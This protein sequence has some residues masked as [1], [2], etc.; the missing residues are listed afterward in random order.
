MML[1]YPRWL[2]R[3]EAFDA[4]LL[5]VIMLLLATG[6]VMMG[7]ASVDVAANQFSQPMYH[8][9]R[10]AVALVLGLAGMLIVLTVPLRF[11]HKLNIVLLIVAVLLLAAVLVPGIGRT[12]N[13]SARWLA[14]GPLSVQA[15]ELAK[16]A[17]LIYLSAYLVRRQ[18]NLREQWDGMLPPL[19]MLGIIVILLLLEPDFGSVVVISIASLAMLFTAGARLL[20]FFL[21]VLGG[22]ASVVA[23]AVLSPYRM[24]RLVTYLDPW[25]DQ[26]DSG[27]Q[28]T[29]ALIAF[30][31]GQWFGVGLGNSVQK[32]SYLPEAHTD[33]VFAI[34]G[35]ELGLVGASGII[36]LFCFLIGRMLQIAMRASERHQS[37]ASYLVVGI[38]FL[39]A[40]QTFISLGVNTGLLPTKGLT[41]PFFSFGGS[42][43]V[44]TLAMLGL[45][46]R[47]DYE[48]RYRSARNQGVGNGG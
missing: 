12:V 23:M 47:A 10:Q 16:P 29:Q 42:S 3:P 4:P 48:A 27:Y 37:F 24:Q 26:F 21:L 2:P 9:G 18:D 20:P 40:T 22:V 1:A 13:G 38:G 34:V 32:L 8:V 5:A 33:F 39:L 41:L 35:E 30:G 36:L 46:L 19:G 25:V 6:L 15:S 28:L 31:R 43:V 44:T 14:I 11:W 17:F 45:V 7:S